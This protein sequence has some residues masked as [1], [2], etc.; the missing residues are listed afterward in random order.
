MHLEVELRGAIEEAEFRK[1]CV[2]VAI[3][4]VTQEFSVRGQT[5]LSR[6][7]LTTNELS[8]L[9]LIVK[10]RASLPVSTKGIRRKLQTNR[11]MGNFWSPMGILQRLGSRWQGW[12]I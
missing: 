3:I 2:Y 7:D 6:R 8:S 10:F 5:S 12:E 1:C 11:E 9:R 4:Q